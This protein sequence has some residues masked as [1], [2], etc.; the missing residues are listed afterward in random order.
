MH[1]FSVF[2]LILCWLLITGHL[3]KYFLRC[4]PIFYCS[5]IRSFALPTETSVECLLYSYLI[6][7]FL[8]FFVFCPSCYHLS[9]VWRQRS[10]RFVHVFFYLY[11][12]VCKSIANIFPCRTAPS[13]NY[14]LIQ[15]NP[16]P[17]THYNF[18]IMTVLLRPT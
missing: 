17:K 4:S 11:L 7:P 12:V 13:P 10:V 3:A 15:V 16:K 5:L 2:A 8:S 18:E 6:L 1:L 9:V 14:L